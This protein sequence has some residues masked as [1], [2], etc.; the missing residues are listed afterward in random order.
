M[1]FNRYTQNRNIGKPNNKFLPQKK[2]MGLKRLARIGYGHLYLRAENLR[3]INNY[4]I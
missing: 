2:T 3:F 1:I 4:V